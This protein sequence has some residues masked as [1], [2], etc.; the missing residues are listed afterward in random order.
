MSTLVEIAAEETGRDYHPTGS[1]TFKSEALQKG[2]EPD[3]SFYFDQLASQVRGKEELD[4]RVDP[5]PGLVIEVDM[6][7]SSLNRL[8]IFAPA[9]VAEVWRYDG[10]IVR[11]YRLED[12]AY[13]SEPF[14]TV[15]PPLTSEAIG[16]L[17]AGSA[18]MERPAWMRKVRAWV[19]EH[20]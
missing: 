16:S 19:R 1:T 11:I 10:S 4:L 17:L 3:S 15:L 6:S 14:S 7:R 9:G 20:S 2:F 13:V 8:P 12:G 18:G 5:A